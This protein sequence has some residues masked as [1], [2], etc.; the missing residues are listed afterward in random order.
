MSAELT[1]DPSD[2]VRNWDIIGDIAGYMITANISQ[3][4]KFSYVNLAGDSSNGNYKKYSYVITLTSRESQIRTFM[5][6]LADA[7]KSN[8][9]YV[10]KRFS[11][12]KQEDQIQDIIDYA[13]GI[14]G[15]EENARDNKENN[16]SADDSKN[17]QEKQT[18]FKET[19]NY[20]ECIAGR[21][22]LCQV[23]L[24]IDYV[25]ATGNQLK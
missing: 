20:P 12:K 7:Y 16:V 25:E 11:M 2:V 15:K 3:L 1:A 8:R 10:I 9:M 21:S 24:V 23:T 14:I 18:Y 6:L 22:T 5:Q 4:E 17:M 13:S 19:R